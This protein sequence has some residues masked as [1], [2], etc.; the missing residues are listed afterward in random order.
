M[1]KFLGIFL[2]DFPKY[3]AETLVDLI[4]MQPIIDAVS[5]DTT[6]S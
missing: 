2:G 6:I 1:A 3:N 4:Q 5:L